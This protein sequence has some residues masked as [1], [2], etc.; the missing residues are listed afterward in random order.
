MAGN[1]WS[2]EAKGIY[3]ISV[4]GIGNYT[5]TAS[6]NWEIA[7]DVWSSD[8]PELDL[9]LDLDLVLTT[10]SATSVTKDVDLS[11]YLDRNAVYSG[12][13]AVTTEPGGKHLRNQVRVNSLDPSS[14]V[15][16]MTL[17]TLPRSDGEWNFPSGRWN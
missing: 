13:Q 8:I 4:K 10:S 9:E 15:L 11:T 6:V 16:N 1:T 3:T 7:P 17:Q 14:H 12:I 2:A 5:G